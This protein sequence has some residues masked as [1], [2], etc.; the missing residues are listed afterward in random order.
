MARGQSDWHP[1]PGEPPVRTAGLLAVRLG[2]VLTALALP[3]AVATGLSL[4]VS[5]PSLATGIDQLLAV[6]TGPLGAPD[7]VGWLAHVAVLG[8]LAGA[9]LAGGGLL[10]SELLD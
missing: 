9:W 5:A 8:L 4:V 6:I 2:V 1:R 7:G 3:L 10:V